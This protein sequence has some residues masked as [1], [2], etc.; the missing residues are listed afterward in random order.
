M[1]ASE[2]CEIEL[3]ATLPGLSGGLPPEGGDTLLRWVHAHLSL[4]LQARGARLRFDFDR[5]FQEVVD[6]VI[7]R[8]VAGLPP[9]RDGGVGG[10]HCRLAVLMRRVMGGGAK[11]DYEV[12]CRFGRLMRTRA[13]DGLV[14]EWRRQY[15]REARLLRIFR[16]QPRGS[17]DPRI[18]K[19]FLGHLV[20][21]S[22]SRLD[23]PQLPDRV[24][25]GLFADRQIPVAVGIGE[26]PAVL[27]PRDGHGG[28][29][30]LIDLLHA[31]ARIEP[32]V[33]TSQLRPNGGS[34][35]II[36]LPS[37]NSPCAEKGEILASP[38]KQPR[39]Q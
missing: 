36:P 11:T 31:V 19:R 37:R 15:R 34:C 16:R 20:V 3:I 22:A 39:S 5:P 17:T 29:C 1:P 32:R 2:P 13:E 24:L 33:T 25:E 8:V 12:R 23:L 6:E 9:S 35:E 4:F 38:S 27:Q 14:A 10:E 18:L 7:A 28:W 26:L 21:G 30:D